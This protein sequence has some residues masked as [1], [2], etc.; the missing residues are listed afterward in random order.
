M[1]KSALRRGD[2]TAVAMRR[3]VVSFADA[4]YGCSHRT[5]SFP[6]TLHGAVSGAGP[7]AAP[8]ETY[9]VCLECG[10]HFAYDWATMR[11]TSR[12]AAGN[13]APPPVFV[14]MSR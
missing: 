4:L 13:T 5:T 1:R 8:S 14:R 9:V 6:M 7:Q 12:R 11:T 2:G 10:R 3:A